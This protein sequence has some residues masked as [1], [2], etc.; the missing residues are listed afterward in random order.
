MVVHGNFTL[1]PPAA[2]TE[3]YVATPQSLH[4][5][6]DK[7]YLGCGYASGACIA[8]ILIII[9]VQ[10]VLRYTGMNVGGLPTYAA[11]MMAAS[12]FLGLPYALI[13]GSHIRIETVSKLMGRSRR[14]LDLIAFFLGTAVTIWF[15]YYVCDM[16]FTTW[17]LNDISTDLDATPLWIPQLTMAIGT[18]LLAVAMADN[19]LTLLLTGKYRIQSNALAL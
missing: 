7:I 11:Y 13:K 12:T 1:T 6:L 9:I 19:F 10:I 15:A 8:S 3:I 14:Y 2:A 16:V 5:V 4:S 18:V 17:K